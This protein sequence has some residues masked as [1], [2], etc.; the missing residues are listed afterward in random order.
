MQGDSFLRRNEY[1]VR[2]SSIWQERM[3][4]KTKGGGSQVSGSG[5]SVPLAQLQEPTQSPWRRAGAVRRR[6]D[7]GFCLTVA[8][9]FKLRERITTLRPTMS[10]GNSSRCQQHFKGQ[11]PLTQRRPKSRLNNASIRMASSDFGL[12]ASRLTGSG[13]TSSQLL[14]CWVLTRLRQPG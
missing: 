8:C 9:P 13:C 10:R 14:N 2:N 4:M 7:S 5:F 3:L 6:S 11:R 12:L 1:A